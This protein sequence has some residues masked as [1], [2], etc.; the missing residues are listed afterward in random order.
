MAASGPS[1]DPGPPSREGT[2][3]GSGPRRKA[4]P[5]AQ[6][7]IGRVDWLRAAT[8]LARP[9]IHLA[10][11]MHSLALV[12][13]SPGWDFLSGRLRLL[14]LRLSLSRRSAPGGRPFA[15]LSLLVGREHRKNLAVLNPMEA[16]DHRP[17]R[18]RTQ[19]LVVL[20]GL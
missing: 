6:H 20:H 14:R 15:D 13:G 5:E 11:P 18:I 3:A 7:R 16:S 19:M 1:Q 17:F 10:A 4:P 9:P 12:E 8:L 2:I